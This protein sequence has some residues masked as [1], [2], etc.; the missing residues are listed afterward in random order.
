M[1]NATLFRIYFIF[2]RLI[3]FLFIFLTFI[4]SAL[5]L[6]LVKNINDIKLW[7]KK[8]L[9]HYYSREWLQCNISYKLTFLKKTMPM[10]AKWWEKPSELKIQLCL[11]RLTH[12]TAWFLLI[13][14]G[15]NEVIHLKQYRT[16][17]VMIYIVFIFTFCVQFGW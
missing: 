10:E 13:V 14:E 3:I 8:N 4:W 15:N 9:F 6:L 2:P 7:Q 16:Q 17:T 1:A 11:I 5:S 12:D